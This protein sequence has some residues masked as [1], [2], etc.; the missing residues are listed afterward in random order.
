M[1]LGK[2]RNHQYTLGN[3]LFEYIQARLPI[4]SS[5]QPGFLQVMKKDMGV[6]IQDHNN[7]LSIREAVLE[8]Q[9]LDKE[10]TT[11]ALQKA[12]QEYNWE[13]QEQTL[14]AVYKD[15]YA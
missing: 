9:N 1:L 4:L 5:N 11:E 8:I 12:A 7:I 6:I 13:N 14:L 2:S 15:L 3:K 10:N